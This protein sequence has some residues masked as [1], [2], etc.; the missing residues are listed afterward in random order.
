MTEF[1]VNNPYKR[2][3]LSQD[4]P[5]LGYC[6]NSE[7]ITF[8]KGDLVIVEAGSALTSGSIVMIDSRGTRKLCRYEVIHGN[9]YLWPPPL[10]T[11]PLSYESL[12]VGKVVEHISLSKWLDL[13]SGTSQN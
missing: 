7:S 6:R 8:N 4:E 2:F 5:S 12:I 13:T 11:D 3:V 1:T 10:G 9:K